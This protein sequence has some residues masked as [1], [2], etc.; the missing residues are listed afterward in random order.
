MAAKTYHGTRRS[1]TE[2][3]SQLNNQLNLCEPAGRTLV[4][5]SAISSPA[6]ADGRSLSSIAG[7]GD[8]IGLDSLTERGKNS[9]LPGTCAD[10]R[11]AISG[12]DRGQSSDNLER[13]GLRGSA[14]QCDLRRGC[15]DGRSWRDGRDRPRCRWKASGQTSR[16]NGNVRLEGLVK[17]ICAG[18]CGWLPT[19]T[20]T[21][22]KNFGCA[23]QFRRTVGCT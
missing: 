19:V 8:R 6:S 13:S 20:A 22:Y 1:Q 17:L 7:W 5:D 14:D 15:Q 2:G 21:D 12:G 10:V 16:S 18:A 9:Q 3:R 23:D 4:S 11:N